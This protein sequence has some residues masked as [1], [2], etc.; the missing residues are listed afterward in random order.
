MLFFTE[1]KIA[2]LLVEIKPTVHREIQPIPRFKFYEGEALGAHLPEFDD[3]A[4]QDFEVGSTWGGYDIRAWF[5][6]RVP[7]PAAWQHDK[8]VLRFLVGPRDGGAST[9]ETL[10]YVNGK[11]L[12][13]IDVWHEEA[14]LPP[15]I[16]QQAE[17]SIALR[18]WSGV[19]AVPDRRRFKVAQLIRIDACAEAYFYTAETALAAILALDA[20]DWRRVRLLELLNQSIN[21]IRF[22]KPRSDEYYESLVPAYALLHDGL[23]ELQKMEP[24]KP[25]IT[26]VGHSHI[27]MAW[28]WRLGATREKAVRTF[29][30]VLHMMRQYPE[31]RFLHSSPQLYKFVQQDAPD[32]FQQ[33]KKRV[34]SGE[35]EITGGAWIEPDTNLTSGESLIRQIMYGKRYERETFGIDSK[36]MWMPDVFGYTWSLP[37]ILKGCGMSYFMT[38][39]ISW[40]K[41]N[42]FPYD[43]FRWRGIDG[44]EVLTHFITT[45]EAGRPQWQY[46]YNGTMNPAE[47]KQVWDNYQQ[48]RLNDDL[49]VSFGW[50]DGGGGPTIEMVETARLMANVPGFP[51]V[52]IGK[53]ESYFASLEQRL[54]DKYDDVPVWDGELY[55]EYH[56]GTY[57]SQAVNK[58]ANRKAEILYRHAEWLGTLARLLTD[59]QMGDMR[60]GWELLLLNQF[61]DILPGTSIR[62]VFEDSALD[63]IR[64]NAIG[65][66]AISVANSAITQQIATDQAGVVVFNSLA[67]RR[68]D[69][70]I[71]S[72]A[73][74]DQVLTDARGQPCLTQYIANG[75]LIAAH[76]VPA[77]GYKTF[78]WSDLAA[79]R[80]AEAMTIT[81]SLLENQFYRIM[82]DER[83]QIT[84]LFDKRSTREVIAAG[85]L[86]NV[87]QAFEDKPAPSDAWDIELYYQEKMQI[88]DQVESI[89]VEETG[90]LRGV[91]RLRRKFYDSMIVQRI[92]LYS[93]SPRIDFVTEI[94]WQEQQ[95]MLK[96]AFPVT[97]RATRATYDIQFG[98]IERPTHWNTSWDWSR[99]EVCGHKWADLSE[100]N[101]GVALLNDCKYGYDIKDNIMRLTLLRSPISP[102]A[103]ADKGMH[104]F[105]YSLLP[106]QGAW[107]DGAVV[108]EA[109]ALNMPLQSID[110]SAQSGTLP[111]D[112]EFATV[113]SDHVLLETVKPAEN[114]DG[115]IIRVYEYKGGTTNNAA[116][117][118]NPPICRAVEC[119]LLE[120]GDT[121]ANIN[122][123][124]RR[125]SFA[126]T[127]YQIKTFRVWFEE[128]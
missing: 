107:R 62:Q 39:K 86:G 66:A 71:L 32:V 93:H 122:V 95:V 4:W 45:P 124:D 90:P 96:V 99:F 81:S 94:D 83:G 34:Q 17:L 26:A 27:D 106:H 18:A 38:I 114:G 25:T 67:W 53:A 84:S 56:Q 61:H 91:L 59:A 31:Y 120:E 47:L 37:Q 20:H 109:Y 30:T 21:L 119:N 76:D 123:Q 57:T 75:T 15:D 7:I 113:E 117:I 104:Y 79:V 108:E 72:D 65:T 49:L 85:K 58:R 3:R 115:V 1:D 51:K 100:S 97:I 121:P 8:V 77:L 78:Y 87:L 88:I 98:N 43:T 11:S 2:K 23:I 33:I 35:W 41:F 19:L 89:E 128:R 5:R 118:F 52:Q 60:E 105:T 73:P 40:G 36:L 44:T 42:R 82:L 28:L 68:T 50:G 111:A 10:L 126:I 29:S 6:A 22:T 14:W 69:L 55:L 80:S 63:Y 70:L 101:Y 12:Q 13:G 9:A 127:P 48:K 102:D 64:I 54:A 103:K 112:Y 46:T 110:I 116:I 74:A 16:L 24:N 92:Y 125:L